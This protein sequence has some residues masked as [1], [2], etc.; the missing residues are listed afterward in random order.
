MAELLRKGASPYNPE[1]V[2]GRVDLMDLT[3]ECDGEEMAGVVF[4]SE[5][6]LELARRLDRIGVDRL[7]L[8]G[9]A[10]WPT[11]DQ[12]E[13]AKAIRALG[14]RPKLFNL[15]KTAP[16][17]DLGCDLG[18]D[19]SVVQVGSNPRFLP[20]GTTFDDIVERAQRLCERARSKGLH[21]S[22]MAM[23]AT[24]T[25][26]ADLEKLIIACK[27]MIDEI[28]LSDS[29]GA[30]SPW[31][32]EALVRDVCA[33]AGMPVHLHP[34]DHSGM[35]TANALA[36][37]RG[38]ASVIH[39]TVNGLGEFA[40]LAALEEVA[41]ALPMH[42]GCTTGIEL[43]QLSDISAFVA[44]MSG[45][46]VPAQKAVVGAGAFAVPENQAIQEALIAVAE[47]GLLDESLSFPPALVG[48]RVRMSMGRLC[49]P[50]AVG[51][52]LKSLG[53]QAD[54]ATLDA[55]AAA[56]RE[57]MP[58]AGTPALFDEAALPSLAQAKGLKLEKTA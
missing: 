48:Q 44:R 25:L 8:L 16:E 32:V 53:L 7:A 36:A 22:L 5:D 2:G 10:P 43:D 9:N 42:L 15:A 30:I 49:S 58:P 1:P 3:L 34:H 47:R 28:V 55:L 35:A 13:D 19:G 14:L 40:G 24:R 54:A 27:P 52:V 46:P 23:D 17:I 29:Q 20:P 4:A 39:C 26:P 50:Q 12:L 37:V 31:G 21:T 57:A 6:R 45:V 38:G 41:V 11:D 51:F 56:V 33:W 18:F